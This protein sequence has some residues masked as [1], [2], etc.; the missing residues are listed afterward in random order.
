MKFLIKK[1]GSSLEVFQQ[2]SSPVSTGVEIF[3][4]SVQSA[5]ISVVHYIVLFLETNS[6]FLCQGVKIWPPVLD[7]PLHLVLDV[8]VFKPPDVG[9]EGR[10]GSLLFFLCVSS[11]LII[12]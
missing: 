7:L 2:F 1:M 8:L 9:A 5:P 10:L 3:V 4:S 6:A 11:M 12:S